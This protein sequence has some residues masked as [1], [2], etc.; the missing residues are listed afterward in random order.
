MSKFSNLFLTYA[1]TAAYKAA[2][3]AMI[4]QAENPDLANGDN[5]AGIYDYNDTIYTIGY[6]YDISRQT[7][8]GIISD[9][10]S[11]PTPIFTSA[12][13]N[14]NPTNGT[15][16][17]YASLYQSLLNYNNGSGHNS[18]TLADIDE[19]FANSFGDT[20]ITKAQ[21]TSLLDAVL[22]RRY[23]PSVSGIVDDC[24]AQLGGF[25]LGN[26]GLHALILSK[27]YQWCFRWEASR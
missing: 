7:G 9:F 27:S 20:G 8:S 3:D 21:A 5:G 26:S 23:E 18:T 1:N 6:G 25:T 2:R 19:E 11:S 4:E 12:N 16:G 17:I 13:T 15:I 24:D 22:A 14:T 10:F